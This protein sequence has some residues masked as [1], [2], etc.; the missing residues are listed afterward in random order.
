MNNLKQTYKTQ[1]RCYVC[2]A[3]DCFAYN[4]DSIY[5]KCT[6]CG[7]EYLGGYDELVKLNQNKIDQLKETI[8]NDMKEEILSTFRNAFKGNKH[9]KIK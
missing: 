2:G 7:K 8:A 9:I 3:D 5:I 4:K 1:L 6:K